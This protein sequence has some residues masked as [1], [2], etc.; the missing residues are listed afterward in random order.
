V[1]VVATTATKSLIFASWQKQLAATFTG[2]LDFRLPDFVAVSGS[3]LFLQFIATV[4]ATSLMTAGLEL[5]P[6]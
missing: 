6:L 1:L 3:V 5:E 4:V 2:N